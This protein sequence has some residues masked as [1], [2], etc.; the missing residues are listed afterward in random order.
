MAEPKI[1]IILP[2]YN[3]P[4]FLPRMLDSILAQQFSDF[5]LLLID[6]G[7]TDEGATGRVCRAYA[8]K[9]SRIRLFS[10]Q[11]NH[12]PAA[13]RNLGIA[14]AAADYLIH[15]DDDDYC[16]PDHLS[17]LYALAAQYDA[18]VAISG[19]AREE[20]GSVIPQHEYEGVFVWNRAQLISEFLKR[21]KFNTGAETKLYR[22][23][24]FQT[25]R[26]VP[27]MIVDDIHV[28]YRL[29]ANADKAVAHGVPT[30]HFCK[31]AGN[32]TSFLDKD[33]LWPEL[34]DEYLEMQKQ[35]VAYLSEM[36]PE[37]RAH[38]RYAAWSYMISM[39]DKLHRGRGKGCGGQLQKMTDILR[40]NSA[41]FLAAPWTTGREKRLMSLYVAADESGKTR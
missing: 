16:R 25:V 34:L 39:V 10:V 21:E 31:H 33:L 4:I 14:H 32:T 28:T 17:R 26:Y 22:K 18:D 11:Q 8:E 2:T 38:V 27:G 9:D 30:F 40:E 20:N 24:L 7:S 29:L 12:G 13:A 15:L 35:R 37:E 3:R 19:S 5:E 36:V 23:S 41:A 6:N 1:S